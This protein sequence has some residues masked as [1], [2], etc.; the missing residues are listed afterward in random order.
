M[1]TIA[2]LGVSVTARVGGLKKGMRAGGRSVGRFASSVASASKRMALFGGG[3]A[4]IA[5]GGG[6]AMLVKHSFDAVDALTKTADK[7][8]IAT[9][10]LGGLHHAANLSGAGT[11]TL[12]KGIQKMVRGLGDAAQG[13]GAAR[14]A[15]K[16]LGLEA[17][18]LAGMT[19]DQQ[20]YAIA[21]AMEGV[22]NQS[23]R[24]S[25]A[26]DLFGATGTALINTLAGGSAALQAMQDDA[27]GLGITFS[28]V[29]AAKVEAANDAITRMQAAFSGAAQTLA[30]ELAPYVSAL[31]TH[32][33]DVGT[34]GGGVG[35]IVTDAFGGIIRAVSYAAD[36]VHVLKIGWSML[37][38]AGT[39]AIL[40]LVGGIRRLAEG[41]NW[42]LELVGVDFQTGFIDAMKNME[43]A[44][45]EGMGEAIEDTK[46][47]MA[48][49]WPHE[50]AAAAIAKIASAAQENAEKV[51]DA[52]NK[53]LEPQA[54]QAQAGTNAVEQTLAGMQKSIDVFGLSGR[55]VKI[56][57][58]ALA[59]ATEQE[60]SH[61]RALDAKLTSMERQQTLMEEGQSV[62]EATRTPLEQYEA[63]LER[64]REV[65][66]SGNI[67][68]DTY[69]R[70]LK[71]AREQFSTPDV[72]KTV[73]AAVRGTTAGFSASRR[74]NKR[75]DGLSRIEKE[76]IAAAKA[77]KE[78]NK[79]LDE[80]A[81]H[82]QGSGD[83]VTVVH[84]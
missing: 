18:A 40:G 75:D 24:V 71:Q 23:D 20:F 21:D 44:L 7:L 77:D 31:A 61:M 17:Q 73:A 67:D 68:A 54:P 79:K 32:L 19:P 78:R 74:M 33:A 69:I 15:L 6:M 35:Q 48:E 45:I 83:N 65:Y 13:T 12:D 50:R 25:V 46:N 28:R 53:M 47:L 41:I 9:E 72:E 26:F 37:K 62:F 66:D 82:T 43:T 38:V 3:L 8:G 57:E 51:A 30:I 4:A 84:F 59:G 60:L 76:A 29:D 22:T 49:D 14:D 80:I 55:A 39:A 1:G 36:A 42:L 2:N 16:T 64:L 56:Y 58:A 27:D 11:A 5:A 52:K 10:K 63:Q 70:A 81:G 34:A